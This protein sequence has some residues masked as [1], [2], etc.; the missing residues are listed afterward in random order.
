[1]VAVAL[2][3]ATS[4]TMTTSWSLASR[5]LGVAT[6]VSV[7]TTGTTALTPP[8][9]LRSVL[10]RPAVSRPSPSRTTIRCRAVGN[11]RAVITTATA[12]RRTSST[13]NAAPDTPHARHYSLTPL[14]VSTICAQ[15]SH[16][17]IAHWLT[18]PL[19]SPTFLCCPVAVPCTRSAHRKMTTT[20]SEMRMTAM[21]EQEAYV[22]RL[23]QG[24]GARCRVCVKM[25][26][27][28]ISD[29]DRTVRIALMFLHRRR[30]A[31]L[32]IE[33]EC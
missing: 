32:S 10:V 21:P 8:S 18:S 29:N 27:L 24:D 14:T 5:A 1:M 9:T 23:E 20:R 16:C 7:V 28:L 26:K 31:H 11:T 15:W 6:E 13:H 17:R 12:M 25:M 2:R 3:V 33:C 30:A 19:T 22:P 4:G